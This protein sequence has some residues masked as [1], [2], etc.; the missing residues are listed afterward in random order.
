M[1]SVLH[2]WNDEDA[3]RILHHL[4]AAMEKGY[5]KILIN[6]NVVPDFGTDWKITSLD[7]LM[8]ALVASAERTEAEWRELLRSVGLKVAGIW[9]KDNG[10]EGLIEAVLEDDDTA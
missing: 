1:H 8:M 9:T 5:S 4:A 7:W 10:V 6:E 3:R 2:D